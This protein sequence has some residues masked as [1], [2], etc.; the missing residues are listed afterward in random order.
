MSQRPDPRPEAARRA[1]AEAMVRLVSRESGESSGMVPVSA[2]CAEAG[3]SR[4]TFYRHFKSPDEALALAVRRRFEAI[5]DQLPERAALGAEG[6]PDAITS[7][8]NEIWD[9]RALYRR[10]LRPESPYVL[11]RLVA[12]DWLEV[13][14]RE[15]LSEAQKSDPT[16]VAFL[17]GG[18]LSVVTMMV[19][20][21]DL[22]ATD[23]AT[24]GWEMLSLLE[25]AVG[26]PLC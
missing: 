3:V 25:K 17:S 14:L 13:T 1:L 22:A 24:I 15:G 10:V 4:P 9:E 19:N 11:P 16:V 21:D 23:I 5:P 6:M 8:L 26:P 2:L 12:T 18:L 7:L 20:N